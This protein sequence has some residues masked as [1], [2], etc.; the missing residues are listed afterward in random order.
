M[1]DAAL[2]QRELAR[3]REIL[4]RMAVDLGAT[5]GEALTATTAPVTARA[6]VAGNASP[7][8]V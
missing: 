3:C 5:V 7:T 8:V 1:D 2:I 6:V 4:D